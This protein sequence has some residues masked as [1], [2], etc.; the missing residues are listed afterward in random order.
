[1]AFF[2]RRR[3][4][5]ASD[6]ESVPEVGDTSP[7]ETPEAVTPASDA[8]TPASDAEP[9]AP[10]PDD[11]P[12]PHVGIS[13]ST[14][15]APASPAG[16]PT[17]ESARGAGGGAAFGP[18]ASAPQAVPGLEDN[19]LLRDTLARAS[20]PPTSGDVVNAARQLLQG[21][22]FLR[23][24]GDARA[25]LSQG[26]ELPLAIAQHGDESVLLVYSGGAALRAAVD[27]D[28][29]LDTSAL[30]QPA[31]TVAQRAL[32]GP[33]AGILLDH[34]SAP[35]TVFLPRAVL[36]QLVAHAD[37]AVGIKTALAAARD[38]GTSARVVAAMIEA[39][40]WLAA[41]RADDGQLGIAEIRDESGTRRL[42]A[43]SHPLEVLALDRGDQPVP[44]TGV[45]LGTILAGEAGIIGLV[46][47][48]AG[49]WIELT[50]DDLA[51][52]IAL[53]SALPGGES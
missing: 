3:K 28:A 4:D 41:R 40:V 11:G 8:P 29:D 35:A 9:D 42:E 15:G 50:R 1:M 31:L 10:A 6:A 53:A 2:S 44:V 49:P 46:V 26:G 14:Y 23:V 37:P 24:K 18:A 22:V 33:Y 30:A 39:G 21:Q 36:E 38:A 17:V 47:D 27:A 12:V 48:P 25:L 5:R 43:F 45:Q 16:P 20:R 13:V 32:E 51:P 52:L 34:A 19:V 7:P